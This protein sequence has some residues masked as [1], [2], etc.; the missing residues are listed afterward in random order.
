MQKISSTFFIS[1]PDGWKKCDNISLQRLIR[2]LNCLCSVHRVKVVLYSRVVPLFRNLCAYI[3][4]PSLPKIF[5]R[6]NS[7]AINYFYDWNYIQ[8]RKKYYAV[9][10]EQFLRLLFVSSSLLSGQNTY[11]KKRCRKLIKFGTKLFNGNGGN[12]TQSFKKNCVKFYLI[13]CLLKQKHSR[14]LTKHFLVLRL[15]HLQ[16]IE[17]HFCRNDV[18]SILRSFL[19]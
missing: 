5:T 16:R 8:C 7:K 9:Y 12:D 11:D 18:S 19:T 6:A 4:A 3:S 13:L 15:N 10:D 14:L 1:H 17:T 2:H